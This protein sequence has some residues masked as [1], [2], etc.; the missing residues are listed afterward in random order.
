MSARWG[1]LVVVTLFAAACSG[2]GQTVAEDEGPDEDEGPVNFSDY[3]DFDVTPY[4]DA[5]ARVEIEIRHDVPEELLESRADAGI[6]QV[7]RGYRVQVF[8]SLDR[9]EAVTVEED[10]RGWWSQLAAEELEE[11]D[12]PENLMVYNLFRQ[13]YYRIRVGDF[14]QRADAERLMLLMF[15]RFKGASVVPDQVIIQR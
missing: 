14:V 3:E 7:V 2:P 4:R 12:M 15:G 10:V 1:L 8:M 5:P 6:T 11:Q 13:P 9:D